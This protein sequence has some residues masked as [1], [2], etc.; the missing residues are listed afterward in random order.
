MK[1]LRLLLVAAT[2]T[3]LLCGICHAQKVKVKIAPFYTQIEDVSVDNRYVEYP[4]ITYK[5]VTYFPMTYDLCAMLGLSVGFDSQAGL[6][7]T[8]YYYDMEYD[9]VPRLFGS[10]HVI[11]EK[12]EYNAVIPSYP[13]YLNGIKIDN[14]KEEYPLLNFR[15]V[16][17]F[18]MTWR[19]AY[20]E[21]NFDIE[22]SKENYSF[23]LER[24][25]NYG[26][27]YAYKADEKCA[28]LEKQ[29]AV[30]EERIN[31]NGSVGYHLLYT[32][33]DFYELDL[34]KETLSKKESKFENEKFEFDR[35]Y[36]R[37][38]AKEIEVVAGEKG[39][40]LGE[41]LI[42]ECN[43]ENISDVQAVEF[44]TSDN[45]SLIKLVVYSGQIV[46]PYSHHN[47]YLIERVGDKFAKLEWDNK[48]N[49]SGV[50]SDKNG[51]YYVCSSGYSPNNM[52]R[53]SNS[54]SD[55]YYYKTGSG[56][57]ESYAEKYSDIINSVEVIG[58]AN[59]KLYVKAM[60]FDANKDRNGTVNF[61]IS[62]VNSG[63]YEIDLESSE[64]T[65]IYP[66]IHGETFMTPNG[67]VYCS[68]DY[69]RTQR[70]VNLITG[71]IIPI[72]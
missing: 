59:G 4:L 53:W 42:M 32:Y 24:G 9:Y 44:E 2:L 55:V 61:P 26:M 8:K 69:A 71:K 49:F 12:E 31:E 22:F 27:A 48:N 51:G 25:D 57:L 20:E 41:N 3:L 15:N 68:T 67:N 29:R 54:F 10:V 35:S 72:E 62:A 34:E 63:F 33:W 23:F 30:Y 50:F 39:L 5:D 64:M 43:T 38:E 7:I 14:Q 36:G 45:S 66:Y 65:K 19:F 56:V 17:Y 40:Y 46:A 18:P 58:K 11:N 47:E 70:F 1:K 28:F 13:V 52:S 16:T 6:Y 60:W 21:L 37:E